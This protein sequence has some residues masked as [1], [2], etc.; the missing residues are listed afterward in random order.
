M[1]NTARFEFIQTS[2]DG[3]TV[4]QRKPA[5]DNRGFFCRFFCASE[6][7]SIGWKKTV[8]QMNHTFTLEKG[9]V[10]GLHFQRPPHTE[11]KLVSCF[12]GEI[13]DVAV[14]IRMGSPTF[15]CWH[16]EILS[17]KNQKSLLIP[18]GFAHGF[19]TLQ[20]NC[21]LLYLH[22]EPYHASAEG[23]LNVADTAIGIDWLLPLSGLSG[24]DQGHPLVHAGFMGIKL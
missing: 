24:R 2:L 21:E 5:T 17:E 12:R 15:L 10:R 18:E 22:S 14:D 8:A 16:G 23:G 13:F 1:E 11:M 9:A 19:Q 3:L 6:F 4:V 7:Q 20:E